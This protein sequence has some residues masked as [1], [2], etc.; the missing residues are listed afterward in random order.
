MPG[1]TPCHTHTLTDPSQ[2][3][4]GG[5]I[6]IPFLQMKKTEAQRD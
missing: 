2:P 1:P 5:T 3:S 4:T 6:I